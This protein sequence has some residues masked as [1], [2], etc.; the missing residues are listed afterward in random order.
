MTYVT[1]NLACAAPDAYSRAMRIVVKKIACWLICTALLMPVASAATKVHVIAFGK[2]TSAQWFAGTAVDAKPLTIKIRTLIVD[3][4]VQQ[5]VLGAPHEVTERLFVVRRAFRVNDALPDDTVPRWRWQRGSWL[6]VDRTTGRI[7]PINLPEFDVYY[8]DASWYRDYV[9]YCGVSEDGKKTYA[10]VAQL[11]RRKPVLKKSL[12]NEGLP[13]DA[14]PDS[15]CPVPSWQRN[16]T[17]VSFE[18][19]GT[20]RQTFAIHGHAVDLVNDSEEDEEASK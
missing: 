9:A 8:S 10:I 4:R 3:G 14:A 16:P 11:S 18:P 20:P 7:S 1:E 17:R 13:D 5:Y 19:A 12:S 6:L 15:A 2:W